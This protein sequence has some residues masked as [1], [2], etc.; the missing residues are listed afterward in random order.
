MDLAA[1]VEAAAL[2]LVHK[3]DLDEIEAVLVDAGATLSF[4]SKALLLIPSAF[5][6]EKYAAEGVE[7][8]ACFEVGPEGETRSLPYSGE[9]IYG[10][11]RQLA[12]RWILE[13]RH[14]LV[15]RVLDWSAEAKGIKDVRARGL[16]PTRSGPVHHGNDW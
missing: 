8:P 3:H 4:T 10:E 7:F 12:R 11:A 15:A 9:P 13:E 16:T 1:L 5:A 6:A 2:E 14:S